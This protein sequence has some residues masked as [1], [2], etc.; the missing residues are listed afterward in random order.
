MG[1]SVT[2][3]NTSA[4]ALYESQGFFNAEPFVEYAFPFS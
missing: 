3:T 4:I 2:D 1:L